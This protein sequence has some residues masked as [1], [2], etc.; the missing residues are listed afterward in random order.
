MS[1][2]QSARMHRTPGCAS[3]VSVTFLALFAMLAMV[4]R[5]AA[6]GAVEAD[7]ESPNLVHECTRLSKL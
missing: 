4:I 6:V 3:M 2:G 7:T 5:A 1:G